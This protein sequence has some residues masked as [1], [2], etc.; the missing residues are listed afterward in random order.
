MGP[1]PEPS[2]AAAHTDMPERWG[3][4]CTP[5][6]DEK[7]HPPWHPPL[8]G[9]GVGAAGPPVP[10]C[11]L[12]PF[13][14]DP[15]SHFLTPLLVH[16]QHPIFLEKRQSR[17]PTWLV[18]TGHQPPCLTLCSTGRSHTPPP[19]SWPLLRKN[20]HLHSSE[21]QLSSTGPAPFPSKWSLTPSPQPM[22]TVP[23]PSGLDHLN[24]YC[25]PK[26]SWAQV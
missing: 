6:T 22:P 10:C 24:S 13:L 5:V 17:K 21:M 1:A 26:R 16:F 20:G 25:I 4:G 7:R 23:S 11:S 18:D 2:P 12:L 14:S 15:V 3:P 9:A 8:S 19:P